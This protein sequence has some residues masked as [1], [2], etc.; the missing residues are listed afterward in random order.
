MQLSDSVF[1]SR[2]Y[3]SNSPETPYA[4]GNLSTGTSLVGCLPIITSSG[5][6]I[7]ESCVEVDQEEMIRQFP[8][9]KQVT[10]ALS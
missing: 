4:V 1:H 5:E 3:D 10:E 2:N 8:D 6:L 9:A 7:A